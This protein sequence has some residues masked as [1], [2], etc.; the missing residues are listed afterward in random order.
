MSREN[1]IVKTKELMLFEIVERANVF[2]C[3]LL[4]GEEVPKI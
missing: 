3:S 2:C 1:V 4:D